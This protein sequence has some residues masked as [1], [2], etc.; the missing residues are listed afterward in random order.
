MTE[1]LARK[2][3]Q[4]QTRSEQVDLVIVVDRLLTGFDASSLRILFIDRKPM[5]PHG[6]IQAF[7]RTNRIYDANKGFG[8]I[9]T[10]QGPDLF[11][12]QV[13]Q[14]L[15][16]YSNGGENY[17]TAPTYEEAYEAF[18]QAKDRLLSLAPTPEAVANLTHLEDKKAFL[19]AFQAFDRTYTAVKVYGEFE[20]E[21]RN[22]DLVREGL[23]P[24]KL[25]AYYGRYK[26]M[27]KEIP[28]QPPVVDGEVSLEI[29]YDFQS[30]HQVL[31]DFNYIL[32]LIQSFADTYLA[33]DKEE[34]GEDQ[35]AKAEAEIVAH[36]QDYKKSNPKAGQIMLDLWEDFMAHPEDYL[37]APISL[38]IDE[39]FRKA[40][41]EKIS[42]FAYDWQVTPSSLQFVSDNYVVD[43]DEAQIGEKE[44][45]ASGDPVKYQ[46]ISGEEINTLQYRKKLRVE[47]K[48]FVEN[49]ILP[50]KTR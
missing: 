48:A 5:S 22:R 8:Q 6:I 9:V 27:K 29:D 31:V 19:S 18:A 17:V 1:R 28:P 32:R 21:G 39:A 10:M 44:L 30:V 50:L 35:L 14:A 11:R 20:E 7:S 49:E 4:Y 45:L 2:K 46:E 47:Y 3:A 42:A 34:M 38:I 12:E 40:S 24:D 41:Q 33:P 13:D 43:R 15:V 26:N 37:Y 23:G 36:L 16:L 25:E